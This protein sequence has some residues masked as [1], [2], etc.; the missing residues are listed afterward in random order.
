MLKELEDLRHLYAHNYAGEADDEYFS[1]SRPR[2]VLQRGV[3][4]KLTCGA[5]FD[6]RRPSLNLHHLRAYA[7]TVKGILERFA[8]GRKPPH[9]LPFLKSFDISVP[10][11]LGIKGPLAHPCGTALPIAS[12]PMPATAGGEAMADEEQVK[13]LRQD[14]RGWNKWRTD[15]LSN[16]YLIPVDLSDADLLG[17]DLRDAQLSRANLEGANLR[18]AK[19]LG[20][21]L[22]YAILRDAN[23]SGTNLIDANLERANLRD[24]NL[25]DAVLS[26]ANL[27]DA[28]LSDVNLSDAKLLGAK[29][30][31]ANLQGTNLINANLIEANLEKAWLGRTVFA[32][33]NLAGATGLEQCIHYAPSIIDHRTLQ[34]S[35]PLP[36]AFLRGVGLP[37]NFIDY[38]SSLLNQAIQH[39]S[40]FISYSTKDQEFAER[41]YADLQNRGVRCWLD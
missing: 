12:T 18:T 28:N 9:L 34:K 16:L 15:N 36:L 38:L 10:D 20:A 2:H 5:E 3:P 22:S 6:G 8:W 13:W 32:N 39:Y 11:A 26:V 21:D 19:L 24:A 41:L 30:I 29:L 27:R 4:V 40:C 33:V 17:A 7:L 14:V 25:R 37:E 35:G 1:P 31:E 23:L